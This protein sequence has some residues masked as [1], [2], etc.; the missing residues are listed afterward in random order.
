MVSVLVKVC[1]VYQV[2]LAAL[3]KKALSFVHEVGEK[4]LKIV[5]KM[6]EKQ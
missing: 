4:G 1:P 3:W 2:F 5:M 6:R